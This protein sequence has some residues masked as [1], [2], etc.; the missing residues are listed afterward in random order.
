VRQLIAPW[1]VCVIVV[2]LL[3]YQ[4]AWPQ[5][6]AVVVVA[7]IGT[8]ATRYRHRVPTV[9]VKKSLQQGVRRLPSS[10]SID[11][12]KPLVAV[13]KHGT[14]VSYVWLIPDV[15]DD[16]WGYMWSKAGMSR[17]PGSSEL[18]TVSTKQ[19]DSLAEKWKLR[20]IPQGTYSDELWRL[21]F[22]GRGK[23]R[24]TKFVF[25]ETP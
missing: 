25:T 16:E 13:S 10:L 11:E 3:L 19:I 17:R 5:A 6:L 1:I 15:A 18:I 23:L 21:H 7:A 14:S 8:A 2:A 12:A 9:S 20:V 4:G 24:S 22:G